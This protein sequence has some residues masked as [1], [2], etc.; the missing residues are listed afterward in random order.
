MTLPRYDDE[1]LTSAQ[2]LP[3]ARDDKRANPDNDSADLNIST[4]ITTL[5]NTIDA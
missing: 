3:L 5:Q 1:M 2:L 4:D